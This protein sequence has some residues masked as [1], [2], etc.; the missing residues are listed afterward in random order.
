MTG[1]GTVLKPAEQHYFPG[2]PGEVQQMALALVAERDAA[3]AR[4][5]EAQ[6][7]LMRHQREAQNALERAAQLEMDEKRGREREHQLLNEALE[8]EQLLREIMERS[9]R[10]AAVIAAL[11]KEKASATSRAEEFYQRLQELTEAHDSIMRAHSN[12]QKEVE[13]ARAQKEE[14]DKEV[15]RVLAELASSSEMRMSGVG[16]S[17]P[18]AQFSAMAVLNPSHFKKEQETKTVKRQ[19]LQAQ[20]QEALARQKKMQDT[21]DEALALVEQKDH[22]IRELNARAVHLEGERLELEQQQQDLKNFKAVETDHGA[23]YL[24]ASDAAEAQAGA[25]D[26]V[27]LQKEALAARE[28]NTRVQ[29]LLQRLQTLVTAAVSKVSK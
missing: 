17:L 28:K 19:E 5:T 22:E 16:V 20:L 26:V 27:R 1:A 21:V 15:S 3:E 4:A 12:L 23:C 8:K 29:Q 25:E 7:E 10:Q 9:E 2:V 13:T 18:R 11:R 14:S 24:D 6:E